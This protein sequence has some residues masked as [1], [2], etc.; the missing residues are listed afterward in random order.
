MND[1]I[2]DI[3]P[4]AP[5][6]GG[7][8]FHSLGA[9]GR[10][11]YVIQIVLQ[12]RGEPDAARERAGWQ[13]LVARHDALRTAF[14]W[15]GQKRPLQVVGRA[16]RAPLTVTD[17]R[18]LAAEAQESHLTGWLTADRAQGFVLT[19]APLLRISRFILGAARHRIVVTFHHAVLDGWSIPVLLRDWIALYAG[20]ALPAAPPFRDHI[21]WVHAQDRRAALDFWRRELAGRDPALAWPLPAP[22]AVPANPRGDIEITLSSEET[23][24]LAAMTRTHG[25]TLATAVHGAW[26]LV[27]ARCSGTDDAVYG[28]ARSGRPAALKGAEGRVGMFLNTLPMRARI[29]AGQPLAGWLAD[30]QARQLAQTPHEHATLAEVQAA[31]GR[32]GGEPLLLSAVVFE[33]YPTDLA[34]LGQV[35]DFTIEAVEVLE[36]T[37]LPLTLFATLHDGLRIRLLYDAGT[38]ADA[39]AQTVL[40]DVARILRTLATQP[41]TPLV[42]VEV[43]TKGTPRRVAAAAGEPPPPA[44]AADLIPRLARLWQDILESTPPA[45]EDNFFDL[46]GHS[47]LVITLQDRIRR[48]LGIAVEIP[49]LFRF[50]TLGAQSGHLARLQAGEAAAPVDAVRDRAEARASGRERLQRRA[51]TQTRD[52]TVDA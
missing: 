27:Q 37:S 46:G 48:E 26:A 7:M 51:R 16:A 6:Q 22:D 25:L 8:L 1:R 18:H 49:D 24:A 50:A 28:L 40:D 31:A 39:A 9:S 4:L 45:A 32:A 43:R 14:V 15:Q 2:Q 41:D 19:H 13:A 12:V 3:Y 34:L 36:Q 10:G 29:A 33:N 35:P 23:T 11:D 20:K 21:A 42:E 47:L 30:L 38:V 52:R 17:L 5:G 44:A